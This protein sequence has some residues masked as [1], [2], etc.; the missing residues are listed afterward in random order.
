MIWIYLEQNVLSP[1][2]LNWVQH[3][4]CRIGLFQASL[5]KSRQELIFI[6]CPFRSSSD[7]TAVTSHTRPLTTFLSCFETK[8]GWTS[9]TCFHYEFDCRQVMNRTIVME[10]F[11]WRL[12][13]S[14]W[15]ALLTGNRRNTCLECQVLVLMPPNLKWKQYCK[16]STCTLICTVNLYWFALWTFAC[17]N[18]IKSIGLCLTRQNLETWSPHYKT[19][20]KS[21]AI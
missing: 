13:K 8:F 15:G 4:V 6:L 5:K 7:V 21:S 2:D 11:D 1:K 18:K 9:I 3:W 19:I 20:L 16:N 17:L 10:T 14:R 12:L